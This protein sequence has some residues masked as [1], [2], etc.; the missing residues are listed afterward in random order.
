MKFVAY[1]QL[2]AYICYNK[3]INSQDMKSISKRLEEKKHFDEFIKKCDGEYMGNYVWL[4]FYKEASILV[5]GEPIPYF[6]QKP[7]AFWSHNIDNCTA[8]DIKKNTGVEI[9]DLDEVINVC[10]E[11]FKES[12]AA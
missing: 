10:L 4:L 11:I 6:K 5:S 3:Q 2:T 12:A 9:E 1:M 8:F 7:K